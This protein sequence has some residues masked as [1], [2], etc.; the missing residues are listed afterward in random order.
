MKKLVSLLLAL[1]FVVA[2]ATAP[3]HAAGTIQYSYCVHDASTYCDEA[4]DMFAQLLNERSDGRFVGTSYTPGTMGNETELLDSVL[5]G[6]MTFSTPADT[7]TFQALNLYDWA[8]LP[9]LVTSVEVVLHK[10]QVLIL[11]YGLQHHHVCTVVEGARRVEE[12]LVHDMSFAAREDEVG[13]AAVL[14]V[15]AQQSLDVLLCIVDNLLKLV[16]GND[17][18]LVGLFNTGKNLL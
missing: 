2:L 5:M 15:R 11:G 4:M 18:P 16:N 10:S 1:V 17:T 13:I 14:D 9:G 7:L 8:S 6:D 12:H 3:A